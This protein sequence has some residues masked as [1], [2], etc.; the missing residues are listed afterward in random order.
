MVLLIGVSKWVLP[1]KARSQQTKCSF[2]YNDTNITGSN[3]IL[4]PSS[5][6]LH[7]R[8][9]GFTRLGM[10]GMGFAGMACE[11][12]SMIAALPGRLAIL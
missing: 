11:R 12:R 1:S 7:Y 8:E 2:E 6:L 4:L 3:I 10:L 5:A 9:F